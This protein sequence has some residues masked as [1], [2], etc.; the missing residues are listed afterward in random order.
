MMRVTI[1]NFNFNCLGFDI[2][3]IDFSE[4]F[5]VGL[6]RFQN[7]FDAN[8]YGRPNPEG[9]LFGLTVKFDLPVRHSGQLN[10]AFQFSIVRPSGFGL[11]YPPPLM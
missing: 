7:C 5:E 9:R 6:L 1:N 11:M 4:T 3:I 8:W 10:S 2:D